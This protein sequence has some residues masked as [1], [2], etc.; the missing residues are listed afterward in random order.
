MKLLNFKFIRDWYRKYKIYL[1]MFSIILI[2]CWFY[3]FFEPENGILFFCGVLSVLYFGYSLF[4]IVSFSDFKDLDE[5]LVNYISDKIKR[6]KYKYFKN[7]GIIMF[8]DFFVYMTNGFKIVKYDELLWSYY[9]VGR[10]R[11]NKRTF[12]I[13]YFLDGNSKYISI[14][15]R[16]KRIV[17]EFEDVLQII[18]KHNS[19]VEIGYN[20]E[21]SEKMNKILKELQK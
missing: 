18:K 2:L 8:D 12:L 19:T 4:Y 21:I 3:Y 14:S 9:V 13:L 10:G 6:K 11:Y 15:S 20:K 1:V 5:D 16:E 7:V 17:D